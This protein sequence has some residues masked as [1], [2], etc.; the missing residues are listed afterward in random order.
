M[1]V[2]AGASG[3]VTGPIKMLH[4]GMLLDVRLAPGASW[5]EHVPTEWNGMA[6]C[7]EGSGRIGDKQA[8]LQ[9]AYV[10]ANE[11]DQVCVWGGGCVRL[12]ACVHGVLRGR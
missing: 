5:A 6:Y 8:Q 10:L 1:R 2:M 3:G 7:Y 12:R 4:P 11:G 9:H